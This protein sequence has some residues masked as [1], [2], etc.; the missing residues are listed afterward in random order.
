MSRLG[1]L[2]H[3]SVEEVRGVIRDRIIQLASAGATQKQA[4]PR[5]VA[6][7]RLPLLPSPT[8]V[9]AE[10][11]RKVDDALVR[12]DHAVFGLE[13]KGM[14]RKCHHVEAQDETWQVLLTNS[15][16]ASLDSADVGAAGEKMV[17]DRWLM[18]GGFH[19]GNHRAIQCGECHSVQDST[20]TTDILLPPI[21]KCQLCHGTGARSADSSVRADC[22]LCHTYHDESDDGDDDEGHGHGV[23]LQQLL[24]STN[25]ESDTLNTP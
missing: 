14:C 24:G 20:E 2:P 17:P 13:A 16:A 22:V 6:L 11:E 1:T 8:L 15:D 18:H 19:H 25:A 3:S 7:P 23:P 12:A 4:D 21:A 9:A 5:D 10:D